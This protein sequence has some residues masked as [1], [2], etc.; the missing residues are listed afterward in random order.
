MMVPLIFFWISLF[1]LFFCYIGYGL[2]IYFLNILGKHFIGGFRQ[3]ERNN[4]R[5][6]EGHPELVKEPAVTLVIAAYNEGLDLKQKLE[7]TLAIDYPTDKLKVI[8]VT[9]GSTDGSEKII[10]EH[11]GVILLHEKQRQGKLAAITRAM[12]QVETPIVVFSDANA[13]LNKE[14]IKKIVAHYDDPAIGGVAGEKKIISRQ[15]PSAIGEAEGLYWQYES[16]MKKQD[17][18]FYTVAGA[19][20]ELFSIRTHLFEIPRHDLI[21]DD[22]ILSMQVCLKGYKI[23]YEPG[24]F[25][26]ELPSASLKEEM[27]RKIRISAGAYQSIGYLKGALNFI[28]HPLLSFQYISR[29]LLRWIFCP[30]MLVIVMATN[31]IIITDINA[32]PFY[33][34]F[35]FAQLF[36][37][38]LALAGWWLMRSGG[39]IGVMAIPFYF[40]FMN[41]CLVRGLIRFIKREQSVQWERSMREVSG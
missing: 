8:F 18:R 21:L 37:Y 31:C 11:I 7:N 27:K 40:L 15:E 2:F 5:P 34:W 6:A 13:M 41:Y 17:A 19:A 36:F 12:R 10:D 33:Y 29:R 38:T 23:G 20:G 25:A 4:P 3:S 26:T 9:D 14:C 24:A 22:F 16:F 39:S 1:T 28:K 32:H 35:L 30:W